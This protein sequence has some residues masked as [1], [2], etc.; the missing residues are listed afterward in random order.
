[1]NRRH[2]LRFSLLTLLGISFFSLAQAGTV[3]NTAK[4]TA[5][6][7]NSCVIN[8]TQSISLGIYLPSSGAPLQ[9]S[10][11]ISLT[12]TKGDAVSVLPISGGSALSGGGS[13]LNYALYTSSSFSQIWGAPTIISNTYD[14]TQRTS[15]SVI[16]FAHISYNLTLSQCEAKT[17]GVA[18]QWGT[19]ACYWGYL[20]SSSGA[21]GQAGL[22]GSG[23]VVN[24]VSVVNN[25]VWNIYVPSA[26]KV[27]GYTYTIPVSVSGSNAP[28]S[29]TSASLKTPLV[30]NYYAKVP[31]SQDVPPGTYLDTV[32]VQ[33]NF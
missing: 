21:A 25:S 16:Y 29:G 6:V 24:G 30:F 22:S 33:V 2:F 10:G 15:S 9:G 32:T 27:S 13:S 4:N 14:F 23:L 31:A 8:S 12:C 26:T 1:M 28:I 7:A 18:V 20:S 17:P 3:T 19:A 5:T 11:A